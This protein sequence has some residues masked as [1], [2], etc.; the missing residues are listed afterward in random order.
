MACPAPRESHAARMVRQRE[1][2]KNLKSVTV[3]AGRSPACDPARPRSAGGGFQIKGAQACGMGSGMGT[4]ALQAWVRSVDGSGVLAGVGVGTAAA[5]A[6]RF[7]ILTQWSGTG[8]PSSAAC[9]RYMHGIAGGGVVPHAE[10]LW[11]CATC[12]SE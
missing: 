3:L 7:R 6:P 2:T 9:G 8:R 12:P 10:R 4:E 5:G 11:C 1:G